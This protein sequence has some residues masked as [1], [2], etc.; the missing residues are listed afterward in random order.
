M[1]PSVVWLTTQRV[2]QRSLTLKLSLN[3]WTSLYESKSGERGVFSRVQVKSKLQKMADEMLP[4][5]LELIHVVK[6]SSDPT[7][8]A[9]YQ[10]LLSGQTIRSQVSNEKYALRLSLELYRLPLQTS[11]TKNIWKTN[12]EEELLG[13][14][15][16][17]SWITN[18]LS[19]RGQCKAKKWLTG[20]ARRKQLRLTSGGLRETW[21][22]IPS[23]A[24]TA[25]KP[26]GTVSQLVDSASG[27]HPRYSDKVYTRVTSRS[28]DPLCAVLE[29]AGVPV[30]DDVTVAPSTKGIQPSLSPLQRAL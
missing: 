22:L 3:E 16:Q 30:E 24:I 6:S 2:T 28:R 11:D 1:N 23:T 5:I 26:S 12:T 9:I 4:T 19:G 20:D 25:I 18:L 27:I 8:S 17:V 13:V 15:L 10:R 29:A 21:V 14:S 7:S